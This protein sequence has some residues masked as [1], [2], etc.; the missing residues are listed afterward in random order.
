M[1]GGEDD[2]DD[3]VD[4]DELNKLSQFY[5]EQDEKDPDFVP[6]KATNPRTSNPP[7]LA[8]R[9]VWPLSFFVRV[10]TCCQSKN[11]GFAWRDNH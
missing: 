7:I 10:F 4:L 8:K 2:D 5:A 1:G 11:H 6:F 9:Q 3:D